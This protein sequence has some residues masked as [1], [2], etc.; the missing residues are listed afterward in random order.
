LG[1]GYKTNKSTGRRYAACVPPYFP[2]SFSQFHCPVMDNL[3]IETKFHEE[4]S[5]GG[6]A[7]KIKEKQHFPI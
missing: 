7:C 5:S 1:S 2:N 4:T 6:A 3:F